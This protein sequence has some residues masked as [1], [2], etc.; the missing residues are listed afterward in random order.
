MLF[1]SGPGDVR[2]PGKVIEQLD[3]TARQIDARRRATKA[4]PGIFRVIFVD[5]AHTPY[6]PVCQMAVN[7]ENAEVT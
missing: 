3:G 2:D 7:V 5:G 1:R 4:G 6:A